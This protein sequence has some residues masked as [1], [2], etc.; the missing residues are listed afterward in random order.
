MA[1]RRRRKRRSRRRAR[2][3]RVFHQWKKGDA[4][5]PMKFYVAKQRLGKPGPK[6]KYYYAV[7]V[8]GRKGAV[9]EHW[10]R[11]AAVREAAQLNKAERKNR[12]LI[13]KHRFGDR[14]ANPRRRRRAR[15]RRR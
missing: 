3:V 14:F 9:F 12:R 8:K 15:S 6:T 4:D 5:R 10:K 7:K 1:R 13:L 2:N 11:S